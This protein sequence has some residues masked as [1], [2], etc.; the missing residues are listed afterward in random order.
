[1]DIKKEKLKA[2]KL[3][4]QLPPISIIWY[5]APSTVSTDPIH[6]PYYMAVMNKIND[7]ASTFP[8]MQLD[9]I[10]CPVNDTI[11]LAGETMLFLNLEQDLY[12]AGFRPMEIPNRGMDAQQR[13]EFREMILH[14]GRLNG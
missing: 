13:L 11:N 3:Q 7:R 5:Q 4:D 8:N 9:F 2:A 6:L 1:M 14:G 12:N 10:F